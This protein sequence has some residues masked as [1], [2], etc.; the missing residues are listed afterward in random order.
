MA[1]KTAA[2][3]AVPA[4]KAGAVRKQ[5]IFLFSDEKGVARAAKTWNATR[6]LL[7]GKGAG[8]FDMTRK[9][10]PVPPGFTLS[11]EVC[12]AFVGAGNKIPADA[13]EQVLAA[14]RVV[15]KQ[16]GKH[17]GG[18]IPGVRPLLVSVRSGARESMPGMMETVLNVGLNDVTV[19]EMTAITKNERFA[20]DSYRRL[21]MMFGGTVLGIDDEKFDEPMD[22]LKHERGIKLDTQLTV[23]DLKALCDTFKAVIK[24]ETG[25]DFPQDVYSQL[26]QCAMAVFRSATGHKAKTYAK[27]MGWKTTL[28]TAV[29]IVTMVFGNMGDDSRHRRGFHPRPVHRREDH[30]RRVSDQRPGRRRGGRH[31]QHRTPSPSWPRRCPKSYKAVHGHHHAIWR[32]TTRTCRMSSSPSSTASCGCSRPATASAPPSPR[33]R[34]P[35][36]WR[37]KADQQGRGHQPRDPERCRHSCCTRSSTTRCKQGRQEGRPL[38]AKGVNASPGAAVGIMAYFDA[39]LAEKMAQGRQGRDHGAP[40]HQAG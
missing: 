18:G 17:F 21:L 9:G 15:E 5:W 23:A 2:K 37:T 27:Q 13:W 6:D 28:P 8:L 16:T 7:G 3:K 39:D 19:K 40:V 38:F 12:D 36:T 34:S 24:K 22:H 32:S 26:K 4:K 10:V 11:T 14:T 33:S 29:N 31:P 35:S 30:V 25:S 20:L 1:V